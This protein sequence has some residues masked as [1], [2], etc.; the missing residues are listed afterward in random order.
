MVTEATGGP[1]LPGRESTY[2][3]RLLRVVRTS[4]DLRKV[5]VAALGLLIF[6]AGWDLFELAVPAVRGIPPHLPG[7]TSAAAVAVGEIEEHADWSR[8]R[9]AAWRLTEPVRILVSPMVSLFQP[10][11][12]A[13][14]TL[15]ALLAIV[16]V[17]VVWGITGGAIARMAVVTGSSRRRPGIAGALHFALRFAVPLILTPLCPLVAIG[18]C[19]L[20]CAGLGILYR[21][22]DPVGSIL[23]GILLFI[24]LGLG[25]VMVLLLFGLVAGW[26]LL[27]ASIAADAQD[28]LDSLSRCFSYLNQRPARF[29]FC[30]L[31]AWVIGVPALIVVNLVASGVV[32]LA[33]WGLSFS[34]PEPN[35]AALS[36]PIRLA[37]G[38]G[39]TATVLPALWRGAIGLLAQGWIYAYFW[40]AGAHIY[41]L[42]RE[43]V[44]GTPWTEV[45]GIAE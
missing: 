8:I 11:K 13:M 24:P 32:Q 17:I 44:D 9:I 4:F 31:L 43:E 40:S 25:M 35:I 5:V 15:R 33:A 30:V 7:R 38:V 41:L 10:V 26:P 3:M 42:F 6:H 36:E 14:R 16:W 12:G 2:F 37:A 1:L 39:T 19:A 20:G 29:A 34:A 18:L 23:G 21:L 27:H 45:S 28:V 22:P